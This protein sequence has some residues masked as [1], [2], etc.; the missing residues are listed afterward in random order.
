M[1]AHDAAFLA[2]HLIHT[3]SEE[4]MTTSIYIYT[5]RAGT[6]WAL[7]VRNCN[8]MLPGLMYYY[9]GVGYGPAIVSPARRAKTVSA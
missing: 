7:V 4:L 1:F 2:S 3:Y 8:L 5:F 9:P 6:K